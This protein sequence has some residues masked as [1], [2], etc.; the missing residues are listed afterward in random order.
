M[1]KQLRRRKK[2]KQLLTTILEKKAII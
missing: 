2:T 1:R